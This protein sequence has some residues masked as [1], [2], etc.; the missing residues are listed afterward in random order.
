MTTSSTNR[1]TCAEPDAVAHARPAPVV[2]GQERGLLRVLG[3]RL[4]APEPD[5][6]VLH[7]RVAR[8]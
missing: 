6:V 2:R 7:E 5:H 4:L 8:R 1:I 3:A